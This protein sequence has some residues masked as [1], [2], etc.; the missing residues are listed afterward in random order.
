MF[1]APAW[2]IGLLACTGCLAV[3]LRRSTT[4]SAPDEIRGA[5][6]APD[7]RQVYSWGERLR[8]WDLATG[9]SAVL[10]EGPFGEGGCLLDADPDGRRDVILQQGLS[11]GRLAAYGPPLWQSVPIDREI[12][13]HD[14]LAA[15]LFGRSGILVIHRGAQV[16]FYQ[17]PARQGDAWPV[18]DIYSIYTPSY[19]GGLALAD[20]N[21]DG[22]PDILCG[23]YWIRS[24]E[25]FELP[26]RLFAINLWFEER[27]AATMRLAVAPGGR[28]I[29]AQSHLADGKVGIFTP[30]QDPRQLWKVEVKTRAKFPHG[31]LVWPDGT[32]M[33]GENNGSASRLLLWSHETGAPKVLMLNQGVLALLAAQDQVIAAC[34]RSL[35]LFKVK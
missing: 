17:R 8:L 31:L 25:A 11:L 26:W 27:E 2:L 23:N 28:V 29:M 20:I 19:Q 35:I 5:L 30:T 9:K 6:L 12:G 16:R 1:G 21:Q 15:R 33:V 3:E 10:A 7:G 14:C 32:L 4:F 18:R 13:M 22:R 24:P 34:R